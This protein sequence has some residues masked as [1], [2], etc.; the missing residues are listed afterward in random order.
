MGKSISAAAAALILILAESPA[1]SAAPAPIVEYAIEWP[2][3]AAPRTGP[4]A[5]DAPIGDGGGLLHGGQMA[6][7]STHEIAVDPAP[8]GGYW[9]TGQNY[10][11]IVHVSEG[12]RMRFYPMGAGSRPHGIVF[13]RKGRL[14]ITLEGLGQVVGFDPRS[15]AVVETYS[16]A[17]ACAGCAAPL[18]PH[19]HGLALASDGSLWF[20][21]KATGTVGRIEPGGRVT[22]FPLPTPG[23][24]PIYVVEG[25]DRAMWVTELTGNMIARVVP[26]APVEEIAV[27]TPLSRPIA[28]A[29]G[30]DGAMWFSEEAGG[31]IGRIDRG[32]DGKWRV[33]ELAVPA[34]QS[35][36][37]LAAL[38]FDSSGDLWV[39]QYVSNNAPQ[40]EGRD[41]IVRVGR[42][43]LEAWARSGGEAISSLAFTYHPAP[44][45]ATVMHRIAQGRDGAMW[46]TEMGTDKVGRV[47]VEPR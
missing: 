38:A 6:M 26:G 41:W 10:D 18:N 47:P 5:H 2:G 9:I 25:P 34:A 3:K 19:P 4:G 11:R 28:V 40:P 15:G 13:D 30:P 14:W 43:G 17:L 12:G 39:Q 37:I 32:V 45:R 24:T 23:S 1:R 31:R 36:L 16:V 27:P 35:N 22:H 7:G 29:P 42:A 44:T 33:L 46:F 8:D 20:T 21:G